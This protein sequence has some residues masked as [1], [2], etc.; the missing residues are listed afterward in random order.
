ML[1]ELERVAVRYQ[2]CF[3]RNF[4]RWDEKLGRATFRTPSSI[5]AIPTWRGQVEYLNTW[6]H[7]RVVWMDGFLR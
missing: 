4:E 2:D 1:A 5:V 3:E 6:L 7:R